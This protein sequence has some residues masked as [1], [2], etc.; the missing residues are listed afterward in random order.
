VLCRVC[1]SRCG[2]ADRRSTYAG[3]AVHSSAC[4]HTQTADRVA[5]TG[6]LAA[7]AAVSSAAIARCMPML[8]SCLLQSLPLPLPLL[9]V[10]WLVELHAHGHIMS[11]LAG[12]AMAGHDACQVL[13][14]GV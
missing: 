5:A 13:Q 3:S 14:K 6:F 10:R 2:P 11:R 7:V 12:R 8:L 1:C 4:I 9:E